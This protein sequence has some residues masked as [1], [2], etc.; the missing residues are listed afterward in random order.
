[1]S[2][3][4]NVD[5]TGGAEF[6][7]ALGRLD[8]AMRRRVQEQLLQWGEDA[9]ANAQRLV[10]VC[11]GYLQSSIFTR[12][13]QWQVEIGAEATYAA[14][15]EFGTRY[16]Q[17]KPYLTPAVEANLPNLESYLLGALDSAKTEA[18]L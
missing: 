10:P 3:S 13:R 6:A 18:Q 15:V 12:S 16:A 7:E 17:A 1:M 14:A 9:K 2:V 11:T 8:S 4:I 5:I